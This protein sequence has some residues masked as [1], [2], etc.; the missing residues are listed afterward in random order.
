MDDFAS[1]RKDSAFL[2]WL[3]DL[4]ARHLASLSFAEVRRAVQ[5]LSTRYVERRDCGSLRDSFGSAGKR[6]GYA[7]FYAPLHFLAATEIVRALGAARGRTRRIVD[8]GCGTGSVGAAWALEAGRGAEVLGI[9]RSAWAVEE[10]RRTLRALRVRGTARRGGAER[11]RLPGEGSSIA[12]G[13]LVNELPP[14]ARDR[15]LR[16]L[17]DAAGR[18]ARIL[19][20]EPV[21]TRVSPWWREWAGTF[22]DAGGRADLW[23][24]RATLP[25]R[26]RL[27]DRAAGLDHRELTARSLWL[28][29]R[30]P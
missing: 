4:E 11:T 26:L 30:P 19:V 9:D 7:L 17:L 6:A 22:E 14:P 27:L 13:W 20:V 8:L 16:A 28:A 1:G 3:E 10:A 23:R 12:A 24:F 25:E 18:G 21:S 5:A 15:L 29:P 2:D